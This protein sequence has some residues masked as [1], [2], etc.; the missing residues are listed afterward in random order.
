MRFLSFYLIFLFYSGF[1]TA[2]RTQYTITLKEHLFYPSQLT[3]PANEKVKL[4]IINLD[5]SIEEFDSFDLN[6]EKVL[7]PHRKTSIYIG[8]LPP[9]KYHFFGEYNPNSARGSILVTK[10]EGSDVD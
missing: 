5:D 2:A 3:I 6:R 8:P 4:V 7:F 1:S 9:G 10:Q